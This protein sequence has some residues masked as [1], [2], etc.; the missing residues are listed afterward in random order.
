MLLELGI[1]N[2][3]LIDDLHLSFS[4]GL[5]VI[6]GETGA[7]KSIL[8]DAIRIALGAPASKDNLR[9]PEEK[10]SFE[11]VLEGEEEILSVLREVFPSGKSLS[12]L[13]GVVTTLPQIRSSLAPMLD[14]YA[15][16]EDSLLLH[17]SSQ[18]DVLDHFSSEKTQPILEKISF[19]KEK[20]DQIHEELKEWRRRAGQDLSAL[21]FEYEELKRLRLDPE[22]DALIEQEFTELKNLEGALKSLQRAIDASSSEGLFE[23]ESALEELGE[24]YAGLRERSESIRIE[25][26]DISQS[27]QAQM[28]KLE[29][30]PY[31]AQQIE[32]RYSELFAAKRKYRLEIDQLF[33]R[34]QEL[35][36]L[37][38][39]QASIE[40]TIEGLEKE[41]EQNYKQYLRLSQELSDVRKE[42]FVG[43]R[44]QMLPLLEQIQ[45]KGVKL[46][47]E[48]TPRRDNK[49][50]VKGDD[51]LEMIVSIN[52]GAL[53]PFSQVLS[54]GELSR[55]MLALKAV[56]GRDDSTRTMIFDEIDAGISGKTAY[57]VGKLLKKLSQKK[58][59]IAITH[60][61]QIVSFADHHY[62]I[63]KEGNKT[64]VHML[65]QEE[66]LRRLALMLS[67]ELTD[68]ASKHAAQMIRQAR[69]DL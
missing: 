58:Q 60:Q 57:E 9:H 8:L 44:D 40:S 1:Q 43:L 22:A 32:E 65:D 62:H 68:T 3:I 23:L 61:P 18:R 34:Q 69:E 63:I 39:E 41:R 33:H 47:V 28:T 51:H 12:R 31:R 54:G 46:D 49:V 10:G 35:A 64:Q 27:L 56:F 52:Q 5:S 16:K 17:P 55:F 50:H 29:E 37:L 48:F 66:H 42:S 38:E 11:M 53:K 6:T 4:P 15:Q 67:P 19:A 21:S 14:I 59:I 20:D 7:G 30:I 25:L 36:S 26:E 13:Q 24:E 45:L 2:F